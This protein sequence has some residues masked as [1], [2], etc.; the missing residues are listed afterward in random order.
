MRKKILVVAE[1]Y[2][3]NDGGV[4]LMYVH[5]RNKYYL[6]NGMDVIVINFSATSAYVKDNVN[7]ITQDDFI[8]NPQDYD[9]LILHAPNVRHH[10]VLLKKYADRFK[11]ILFFFHGHEVLKL[12]EV[13][14]KPYDYD[15]QSSLP[16]RAFQGA[17]D[18]FKLSVW[19]KYLPS[20][21][22]KS[23]FVFV[24]KNFYEEFKH[25]V[26]LDD[27]KLHNHVHIIYNGIGDVFEST[28]Y[29][30]TSEKKYDF[31]TI[32]NMLD[33]SVYCADLVAKLAEQNPEKNFLLIGRGRFFDHNSKP[34]NITCLDKFVSHQDMLQYINESQVALM[35]TRRDTQGVMSCELATF[36]IPVIT[37][38]LP[39]C[40]EV[41]ANFDN[42]TMIDNNSIDSVDLDSIC[43][44]MHPATEKNLTYCE[45]NTLRKEFEL[46]NTLA[47][48]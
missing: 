48:N 41:F 46:V 14:P 3:N 24:S 26:K 27:S 10:Y 43:A 40:Q 6:A 28:S 35:L 32:R 5:V 45:I 31:I 16:K 21:A 18:S 25:Y 29:N 34:D 22:H 37:S 47:N 20:I 42:V 12:N 13:Y 2:P 44:G 39:V 1:N 19:R 17:Y 23:H 38:N 11:Q 7:V 30:L 9:L 36:G 15:K 33:S 8:K 4:A